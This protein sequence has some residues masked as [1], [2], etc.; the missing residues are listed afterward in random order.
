[1]T[2]VIKIRLMHSGG[3]M[4]EVSES[5]S[6]NTWQEVVLSAAEGFIY[7]TSE[8]LST[9]CYVHHPVLA[10]AAESQVF[11]QC[12]CLFPFF[13][14]SDNRRPETDLREM[15]YMQRVAVGLKLISLCVCAEDV[16]IIF[17]KELGTGPSLSGCYSQLVVAVTGINRAV[18]TAVYKL[19]KPLFDFFFFFSGMC[20]AVRSDACTCPNMR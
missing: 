17:I 20:I 3:F 5:H 12:S 13:K 10:A 18:N 2:K 7:C 4:I 8:L 6:G 19:P 14:S 11:K 15:R 16:L 9:A 1:M